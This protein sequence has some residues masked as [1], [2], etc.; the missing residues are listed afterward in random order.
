MSRASP[1]NRAD[2]SHENLYF[3][4]TYEQPL[5]EVDQRHYIFRAV[6][7]VF[8]KKQSN[9]L[10][11]AMTVQVLKTLINNITNRTLKLP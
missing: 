1:A 8:N 10:L 3:S 9:E 2:L 7:V 4:T 5:N 6:M 11:H